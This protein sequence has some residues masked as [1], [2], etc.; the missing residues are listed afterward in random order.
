MLIAVLAAPA[1]VHFHAVGGEFR[2]DDFLHLYNR[3]SLGYW[4]F[5][6]K[7]HGGHVMAAHKLVLDSLLRV[8]GV[9][10]TAIL[11]AFFVLHLVNALL[12]RAVLERFTGRPVLSSLVAI[13]WSTAPIH[14]GT[15]AWMSTTGH[16]LVGTFLLL[17]LLETAGRYRDGGRPSHAAFL[18]WTALLAAGVCSFGVG[19]TIAASAPIWIWLLLRE[20]TI[21]W[22]K[23]IYMLA[24]VGLALG[25]YVVGRRSGRDITRTDVLQAL[26]GAAALLLDLA[27]YGFAA[28][29]G[30]TLLTVR[31][32]DRVVWPLGELGMADALVL[33]RVVSLA[34]AFLLVRC[35]VKGDRS[36]RRLILGCVLVSCAAYGA[37]SLGR[38]GFLLER[39][40]E[41]M[42]TRAK[43]H[44]ATSIGFVLALGIALSRTS[45]KG[46][47]PRLVAAGV[48][49]LGLVAWNTVAAREMDDGLGEEAR[50]GVAFVERGLATALE[51]APAEEVYVSNAPFPP[52]RHMLIAG[53]Q[54][55]A[56]P[57]IFAYCAIAHPDFIVDGRELF[58]VEEDAEVVEKTRT[59]RRAPVAEHLLSPGEAIAR[60]A[61]A[62]HDV[63]T[64][65][66]LPAR[67]K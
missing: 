53:R 57:G 25:A 9:S 12:V 18:R 50:Q 67:G 21:E 54:E 42:A 16:V 40:P 52:A 6:S 30:A 19:L 20:R 44:Y 17:V 14:L 43:Y 58:F 61:R 47:P 24:V 29:A 27:A 60:G 59:Q 3:A 32:D 11:A 41:W 1:L 45:W 7:P 26:P 37:I 23:W 65:R 36:T 66:T 63:R 49:V 46:T 22:R 5:V 39:S 55:W 13:V 28:T 10:S 34:L 62:V 8:F 38:G 64:G 56:F 31:P 2:K 33:A 35:F 15:I 51:E 48:L 4:E